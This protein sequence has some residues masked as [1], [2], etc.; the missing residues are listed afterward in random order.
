MYAIATIPLINML[1]GK[2]CQAW[3]ADDATAT[4][5]IDHLRIRLFPR[6]QNMDI[7]LMLPSLGL[8]FF[9]KAI[10]A[11]ENTRVKVTLEGRP[12]LGAP[13]G[14]PEYIIKSI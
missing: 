11:F 10:D 12:H 13:L 3:Y 14:T 2:V 9:T 8:S 5:S 1:N 7:M 6:V 4:G